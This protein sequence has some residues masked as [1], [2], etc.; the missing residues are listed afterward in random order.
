MK[1]FFTLTMAF[2]WSVVLVQ[3]QDCS[4]PF[5]LCSGVTQSLDSS[6]FSGAFNETCFSSLNSIYFDFTTNNN[7]SNPS[8]FLPYEVT[9]NITINDCLNAGIN[10]PVTAGFYQSTTLGNPCAG[11]TEIAPCISDSVEISINSGILSPNTT[12]VLVLGI[13]PASANFGCE[14]DVV[15]SGAPLEIN[16]CCEQEIAPGESSDPLAVFGSTSISGVESYVWLP[17]ESLDDFQSSTPIASPT[18]TTTY[19]VEADVGECTVT[20]Q[21]TINVETTPVTPMEVFSPNGDGINDTWRINDI[22]KYDSAL[23][24]VYDRWG[25]QVF[26]SI[27]YAEPWDGTNEGKK[28]S[29]GSYYYVIELNSLSAELEPT[30]GFVVLVN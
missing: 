10:L 20:D 18:T 4:S 25:Q 23:I 22:E 13:D 11:L 12:Y 14:L 1:R 28:L 7:L 17:N 3:S 21:V 2:L 27:G 26:K 8:A 29:F 24:N 30:T 15:L 6:D 5:T 9:A 19:V 16:A